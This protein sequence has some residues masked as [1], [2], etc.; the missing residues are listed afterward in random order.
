[1][2]GP[3][4]AGRD[5]HG[6]DAERLRHQ[7]A[8]AA[9]TR[10]TR[11]APATP[12]HGIWKRE[13]TGDVPAAEVPPLVAGSLTVGAGDADAVTPGSTSVPTGST[14]ST[15]AK[16]QSSSARAAFSVGSLIWNS[17]TTSVCP[18]RVAAPQNVRCASEVKPVLPPTVPRYPCSS[19]RFCE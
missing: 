2:A 17:V 6:S 3:D 18:P 9:T 1:V 4:S 8:I 10:T 7:K 16:P 13:P 5:S 12:G 11:A 14:L 15:L 19:K